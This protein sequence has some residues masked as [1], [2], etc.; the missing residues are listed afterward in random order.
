MTYPR[1]FELV[2]T[3]ACQY[4]LAGGAEQCPDAVE[5]GF[6]RDEDDRIGRYCFGHA[7]MMAERWDLSVDED[8]Q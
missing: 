4:Q 7:V 2:S 5:F 3:K 8:K 1:V 6:Q